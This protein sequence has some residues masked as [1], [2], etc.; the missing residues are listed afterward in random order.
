MTSSL[1][2]E[3]AHPGRSG[4]VRRL[5]D[6]LGV[7]NLSLVVA[8]AVVV[9]LI[10][11]QNN[12]F[13]LPQNLLN[14]GQN[15]SVVGLVA[16]VETVIIVAGALDISVG[17]VAGIAS[18]VAGLAVVGT[19]SPGLG[20]VMGMAAG[21]MAGVV[22]GLIIT[23]G[24]VNPVI[25]T[26]ATL[27]AFR[28]VAFL[29]APDGKPVGVINPAFN[30]IGAGRIDLGFQPGVPISLVILLGVALTITIFLRYTDL[31]RAVYAMGGNP[32]AARLA[33]IN[34]RRM[35]IGIYA[36]SGMIAGLA[37]I[38]VTARTF[39]GQPESGTSGLELE[40]ITAAFLGGCSLQGGKGTVGGTMLAVF[41]IGTLSNGMSLLGMP[42]FYQLVAKGLLLVLAVA[43][44]QWRLARSERTTTRILAPAG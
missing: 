17:A 9:G 21:L 36:L 27:S 25:A 1:P 31:G 30:A 44:Q 40:A 28:G 10:A 22:N 6:T 37:G 5:V 33:G 24:R 39:S 14:I 4:L 8:L 41:L 43:I 15:V 3:N 2:R 32:T 42:T 7:Q 38:V 34:L 16:A 19:G 23:L 18:V 29:I 35:T 11:S 20:V 12:R 13:F 26:L